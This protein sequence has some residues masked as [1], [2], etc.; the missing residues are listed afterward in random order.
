M[1]QHATYRRRRIRQVRA[2]IR[3]M[4][5]LVMPLA[6]DEWCAVR[7]DGRLVPIRTMRP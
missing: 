5:R 2:F 7:A 1:A 4:V 3:E 6:H